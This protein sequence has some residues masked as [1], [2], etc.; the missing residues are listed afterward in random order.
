[1]VVCYLYYLEDISQVLTGQS[2]WFL[3]LKKLSRNVQIVDQQS[4]TLNEAFL[5]PSDELLLDKLFPSVHQFMNE[6]RGVLEVAL[7]NKS[8]KQEIVYSFQQVSRNYPGVKASPFKAFITNYM[9]VECANYCAVHLD[10]A[11]LKMMW[12]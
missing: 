2:N 6:I 1:M 5:N 8:V 12:Q 9:F 3:N 10:E 4:V 7:Q 11:D